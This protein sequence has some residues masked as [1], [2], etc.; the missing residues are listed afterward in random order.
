MVEAI[1]AIFI[2]AGAD[3][4]G[5]ANVE[6]FSQ[7]P[8]GFRPSDI[9]PDCRSV[10]VFAKPLPSGCMLVDPRIVYNHYGEIVKAELDRIVNCTS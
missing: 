7:A 3:V 8:N 1:K 2:Q 9:Y 4:C 5:A 6:A 10:V